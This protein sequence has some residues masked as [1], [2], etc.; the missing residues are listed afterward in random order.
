MLNLISDPWIPV[1]CSDGLSV[2]RPDQIAD[3]DVLEFAWPRPDLNLA[4]YEL[5]IGLTYLACPPEPGPEEEIFQTPPDHATFRDGLAH[6]A[7]AFELLGDG[8]RFLQDFEPLDGDANPADSLFI[9]HAGSNT[10]KKN[11]DLMVKRNRYDSLPLPLAAMA[12]YTLQAFAPQGGQGHRTSMRGGGPM[13]TL[14]NPRKGSLWSLIWANVPVGTAL[15]PNQLSKLPWMRP[16]V[17]SEKGQVVL[18]EGDSMDG[19]PPE[20]FFGQPLRLRLIAK[21]DRITG[22]IKKTHGTKYEGWRH[23]LTP[24]H[25]DSKGQFLPVRPKQGEFRYKNWLGIILQSS[26]H[27]QPA[28]LRRNI[29]VP[30]P[31]PKSLIVAGWAMDSAKPVD[32]IWSEQP[33]FSLS[34][35][36][37]KIVCGMVEAAEQSGYIMAVCI[38]DCLGK[39]SKNVADLAERAFFAQTHEYFV[40][41]VAAI[42]N[43]DDPTP[44]DWL[45][46]LRRVAVDLFDDSI[47]P[48]MAEMQETQRE[49]A[50][51]SRSKLLSTFSGR[52][53]FAKKI[54]GPLNLKLPPK[55]RRRKE[56]T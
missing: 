37:N 8:P 6:L 38:R 7:P 45:S 22:V 15:L 32:F 35:E 18:P 48:G 46:V 17:T 41:R 33:V 36:M 14:V 31:A 26:E 4:C 21:K 1:H 54:Y 50:V 23:Y 44:N 28:N 20:M 27:F 24:Y 43:G 9:D 11:S 39:A 30:S 5:M 29:Q 51:R 25:I 42:S 13:V 19:H 49:K 53:S 12:L 2:V 40:K 34:E 55:E 3:S 56:D 47:L 52:H 10:A 16:T